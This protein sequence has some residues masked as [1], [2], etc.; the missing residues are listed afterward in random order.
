MRRTFAAIVIGLMLAATGAFA[1]DLTPHYKIGLGFHNAGP[2]LDP[3]GGH[4]APPGAPIGV[5]W[6]IPDSRIGFD[7]GFGF[8]THTAELNRDENETGWAID[9]GLPIVAKSWDRVHVLVR[10]GFAYGSQQEGYLE[11][12]PARFETENIT[13]WAVTGE[14]EAEVFLAD[15]FSVSAATGIAFAKVTIPKELEGTS[16]DVDE[17][18][19]GTLGS[20]FTTI[21]F[22][23][24]LWG[25]GGSK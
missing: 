4:P 2:L 3:G 24:Y 8:Q 11:G 22:H 20:D 13:E 7:V 16:S 17:S 10:P 18:L 6:W 21:G 12:T 14:A 15:N 19:F 5:R 23:V 1:D 25:G 9:V